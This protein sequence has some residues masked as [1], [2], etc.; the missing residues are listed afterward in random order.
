MD[1]INHM[2]TKLDSVLMLNQD[3][4]QSQI[5]TNE[6]QHTF[7]ILVDAFLHAQDRVIQ[8]QLITIDKV[9]DMI[10]KESLPDGLDFPSFPSLKLSRLITPIIFFQRTYFVYVLQA[11]LLQPTIYQLYKLQ[12]F[13]PKQE[14]NIFVYIEKKKDFIFIDVMG[15]KYG[16]TNYQKLQ[17]C[18]MPNE[19]TCVCKETLPI[20]TSPNEDCEITLIHPSTISLPNQVC[21]LRLLNL[22]HTTLAR[23]TGTL[24]EDLRTFMIISR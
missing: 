13:P 10:R 9:K 5:G 1:E 24:H 19:L 8:P 23:K 4:H 11:P 6:C 2:Q 18:L 16:K 14:E 17:A 3:I 21:E 12:R 15:H 20:L 22:E 7:E